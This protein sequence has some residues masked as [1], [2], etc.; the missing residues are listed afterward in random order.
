MTPQTKK[1]L[2][3]GGGVVFTVGLAY[4]LI[5]FKKLMDYTI[6]FSR[7]QKV[8]ISPNELIFDIFVKLDNP[9]NLALT[10]TNQNYD[11]YINNSF[12]T[13][14]NT[15]VQTTLKPKTN[16][17]FPLRINVNPKDITKAMGTNWAFLL[18]TPEK[19]VITTVFKVSV[20]VLGITIPIKNKYPISLAEIL[21]I[22]KPK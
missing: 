2:W 20:K 10:L 15:S 3:I 5:Q 13:N 16:T 7:F 6:K 18:L 11:V 4:L 17:E 1:A 14:V 9:S 22:P 8:K 19:V 21:N 12:V